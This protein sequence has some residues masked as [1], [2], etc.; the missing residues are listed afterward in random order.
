VVGIGL[1]SGILL[2]TFCG[3]AIIFGTSF[4]GAIKAI[5]GIV[6]GSPW[7]IAGALIGRNWKNNMSSTW[8]VAIVTTIIGMG[9][10]LLLLS[11]NQYFLIPLPGVPCGIMGAMI[12]KGWEQSSLTTW[13][14]CIVGAILGILLFGWLFWWA[15]FGF[16]VA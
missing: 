5:G 1:V 11:F 4:S 3:T 2:G 12:G 7:G 9:S 13:V 8:I 6:L 16:A 10:F 14:G 15:S